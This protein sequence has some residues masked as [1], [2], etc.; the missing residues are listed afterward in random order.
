MTLKLDGKTVS[1]DFSAGKASMSAMKP[2]H[3][4]S[5][6]DGASTT[7]TR[8]YFTWTEYRQQIEEALPAAREA[9]AAES[10]RNLT[11]SEV[12]ERYLVAS[13]LKKWNPRSWK[14]GDQFARLHLVPVFGNLPKSNYP[15]PDIQKIEGDMVMAVLCPASMSRFV[16][17]ISDV[18]GM[19]IK[20]QLP[21]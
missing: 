20:P 12:F 18:I 5:A 13:T 21:D 2:R 6:G 7:G 15:S 19:S 4:I 17:P 10:I 11:C 1:E 16:H 8:R 14:R 9:G 3:K